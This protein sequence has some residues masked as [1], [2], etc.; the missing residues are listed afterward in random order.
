[1]SAQI[2][3]GKSIAQ[4]IKK[5]L[6][7]IIEKLPLKPGLAV[8]LVG[9]NPASQVYVRMKKKACQ[10]VGI[11]SF[12]YYLDNTTTESDLLS[13]LSK[14]NKNKNIHG[15]LVQLPLPKH[16]NA[17][18]IIK[19]I[20]PEKDV[21]GFHPLSPHIPCTPAGIIKLIKSTKVNIASKKAV[22]LGRSNIVGRPVANLLIKENATVTICH[23]YTREL[24]KETLQAD[25]LVS[26]VGRPKI[27][28][29][30]MVK[31]GA[32]VID[33]GTNRVDDRLVGD[34][35]FDNVKNRAAYLTP[36]PGGVGPMTITM[37]LK[38]TIDSAANQYDFKYK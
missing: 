29:E 16:I 12:S 13:L 18:N 3:N 37:L 35:D 23:S 8:V 9:D 2:I 36:V 24:Q 1:M 5:D 19:A 15:I 17:S 6:K 26:A 27:I 7:T 10:E 20:L 38:N 34:V 33:V 4:G 22:V 11:E 28:T 21:D 25:I 31:Q 30:N 14:L 32:I